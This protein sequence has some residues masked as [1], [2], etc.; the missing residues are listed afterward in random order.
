[1][2]AVREKRGKSALPLLGALL[3]LLA[4]LFRETAVGA[5]SGVPIAQRDGWAVIQGVP[6]LT[7]RAVTLTRAQLMQGPLMLV[8]ARHPLPGDYQPPDVRS[9]LSQ[10]GRYL[11]GG[12]NTLLCPEVIYA[13][14]SLQAE[15]SLSGGVILGRGSLS[16]AQQE[17]LRRDA[18]FRYTQVYPLEEAVRQAAAAPGGN[19]SEHRTGYA[20]DLLL[21]EPEDMGQ[22]N[23]LLRT[24]TG[25]WL[26]ENLWR[27]GFVHRFAPD[28]ADE[29]GCESIHLRYVGLPHAAAMRVLGLNLEAYLDFLHR[30]RA[31]TLMRDN[32]PYAYIFCFEGE[33][34]LR[35]ILPE[36]AAFQASADNTG[37]CV[38][39]VCVKD[40][41]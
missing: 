26:S 24:E 29:G 9:V 5:E 27:F 1:M 30:E 20:V 37:W 16:H 18:F 28:S 23:P 17:S 32:A 11:P 4:P 38:A 7:G 40:S 2:Y 35:L 6:N 22:K 36:R 19:E 14:C 25:K 10:V 34:S 31:V 3:L 8:S 13:L 12:E 39:A 15:H 21:T 41:F 33:N